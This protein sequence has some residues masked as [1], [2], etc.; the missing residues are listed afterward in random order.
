M[1]QHEI[2]VAIRYAVNSFATSAGWIHE[3]I[4]IHNIQ[5]SGDTG[6]L[7][8]ETVVKKVNASIG[9]YGFDFLA[10]VRSFA[11]CTLYMDARTASLV[12]NLKLQELEDRMLQRSKEHLQAY[13]HNIGM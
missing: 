6:L 10:I 7:D 12:M 8:D 3:S 9:Q 4:Q 2:D 13:P 11:D 1:H 5:P